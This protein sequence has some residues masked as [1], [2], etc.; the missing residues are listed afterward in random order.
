MNPHQELFLEAFKAWDPYAMAKAVIAIAEQLAGVE[1]TESAKDE[2]LWQCREG[3]DGM[4]H[5]WQAGVFLIP[6]HPVTLWWDVTAEMTEDH[7]QWWD[8]YDVPYP[9]IKVQLRL[10][11]NEH[12][13]LHERWNELGFYGDEIALDRAGFRSPFPFKGE[14]GYEPWPRS[15]SIHRPVVPP[16]PKEQTYAYALSVEAREPK[17]LL[18]RYL[19]G[20]HDQVWR[21]LVELGDDVRREEFLSDAVAVARETMRRCRKNV[22]RLVARLRAMDYVFTYDDEV[23]LPPEPHVLERIAALERQV[24]PIPLSLCAWYEIVGSVIFRGFLPGW[25]DKA[26]PDPLE[27]MASEYALDYDES[28]WGRY[29][30]GIELSADSYCKEDVSGGPPYMIVL[31]SAAAD[32]RLEYEPHETEFVN[33]LRIC[34]CWG[35][36]PGWELEPEDQRPND[37][38]RALAADLLP[39]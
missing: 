4:E 37:I 33:Y 20:E 25:R 5:P 19:A 14:P 36:F 30:Y 28:N 6:D 16:I 7:P 39:V 17:P 35:G 26:Y 10:P 31:P 1:C 15:P 24:G 9:A 29:Q 12:P 3:L 38:L 18:A 22:E 13:E 8:S 2:I 21:T 23:V 34:F 27:V 11:A 32:A